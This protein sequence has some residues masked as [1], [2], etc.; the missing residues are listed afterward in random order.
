[1]KYIAILLVFA[2]PAVLA[3]TTINIAC[4]PGDH[5]AVHSVTNDGDFNGDGKI[6]KKDIEVM[7]EFFGQP[8]DP[9]TDSVLTDLN[10]DGTTDLNDFSLLRMLAKNHH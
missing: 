2:A 3:G 6:D 10:A 5:V 8:T 7:K 1:M 9:N 4:P